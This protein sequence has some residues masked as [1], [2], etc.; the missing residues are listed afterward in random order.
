MNLEIHQ[1]DRLE[2]MQAVQSIART[3]LPEYQSSLSLFNKRLYAQDNNDK[4]KASTRLYFIEKVHQFVSQG[5]LLKTFHNETAMKIAIVGEFCITM[6]YLDNHLQDGKYGVKNEKSRRGNSIEREETRRAMNAYIER[7]FQGEFQEKIF[8]AVAK[9]FHYYHKGMELDKGALTFENYASDNAQ[10]LHRVNE[11]IDAFVNVESLLK[12]FKE[13]QKQKFYSLNKYN[14]LRLLCTR[15]F[16]INTVFFQIFAE[17]MIDLYGD[18]RVSYANVVEYA[19][20]F[21]ITQQLVND[22]TDYLPVGYGFTTLCKW[23]EDTFCDM[24]RG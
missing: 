4:A 21:G 16:L 18:P 6:M 1:S 12:T 24:R 8:F 7:E 11:E 3:Y 13:N 10:N 5:P 19:R 2:E 23:E 14:Y 22:N 9:L 17:L 20:L 15:S